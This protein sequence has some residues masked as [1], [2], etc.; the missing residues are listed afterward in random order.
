[1][2]SPHHLQRRT[3]TAALVIA[4]ALWLGVRAQPTPGLRATPSQSE[5]PFY[6]VALHKD[7]DFDLLRNGSQ[8][9][10]KGQSAWVEGKVSDLA[11]KPLAARRLKSG[12]AITTATTT[13]PATAARL[14][15]AFRALA[16]S[17]QVR[18]AVTVFAR[19]G[20]WLTPVAPRTSTSRSSWVSASC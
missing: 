12:N 13:T 1:M 18:M 14:T 8:N 20:P 5:G 17:L 19:C 4:P 9:Y 6:P 10:P 16:A 2:P 7:S 11:D 15:S 3:L